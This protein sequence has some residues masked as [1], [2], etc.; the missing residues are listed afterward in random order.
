[1]ET[2]KA[3]SVSATECQ[4]GSADNGVH[5]RKDDGKVRAGNEP[6]NKNDALCVFSSYCIFHIFYPST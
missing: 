6:S 3:L 1:M 2:W 4:N 5:T